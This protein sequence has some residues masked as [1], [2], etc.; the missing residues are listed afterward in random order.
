M[1]GNDGN[2]A[3][4]SS[5]CTTALSS[6]RMALLGML[7]WPAAAAWAQDLRVTAVAST[8]TVG[9]QDQFQLT[10]R[11]AGSDI[12]E[13]QVPVLPRLE[14]LDVVAGPSVSTQYQWV[15]GRASH[16]RS[17]IYI[18]VPTREGQFTIPP[19]EVVVAGEV[20]RTDPVEIR[21]TSAGAAPARG[22]PVP[23]DPSA[24]P[25]FDRTRPR[26]T[27]TTVFVTAELDRSSAYVG[28]QVTLSYFLY[29]QVTVSG[30]QLEESPALNGFWVED[31]EIDAKPAGTRRVVDGR[32]YL[33]Y[34][35]K[36][37]ALFPTAPGK[38]SVPPVTFAISARSEGG[39]FDWFSSTETLYRKSNE[40]GIEARALPAAG[41]PPNFGGA[42]GS[43]SLSGR[44][45]KNEVAAGD[46]VTLEVK[47]AG[48]GNLRM[49]PDLSLPPIPD[50]TVYS[51]KRQDNLRRSGG[52]PVGGEMVWEYIL[53]PSVPGPHSIRPIA[54]SFFDPERG[55]YETVTTE[56]L[57]VNVLRGGEN[58]GL[59]TGLPQAN[60]QNLTRQGTDIAFIKLSADDLSTAAPPLYRSLWFFVIAGIPVALNIGVFLLQR[61]RAREAQNAPLAR[62]RRARAAAHA[63]LKAAVKAGRQEP[64]RF[65]DQAALALSGYLEDRFDLPGI[66]LTEDTLERTLAERAVPIE[67]LREA[68]TCL[69]ECDF[70]RFVSPSSSP[71]SMQKLAGR[72]RKVVQALERS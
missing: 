14:G 44:V 12:G 6:V 33:V 8:D 5:L 15:N 43:F 7:L 29:T 46:A 55:A 39:V 30:L 31:L 62:S 51:S 71:E 63:R 50:F 20:H 2:P 23:P 41:R 4:A 56:P 60:R 11:I 47:L 65:Y 22:R 67:T 1:T 3:R 37:Q 53:V 9:V 32:E 35:V 61:E 26:S 64:R 40:I 10:I 18:L 68:T 28:Q 54:F 24:D 70:G 52:G 48:R 36:R 27:N 57:P 13:V 45:N 49:I 16:S 59:I 21:V 69:R 66:A 34:L 38:L 42:V 25:F 72:I 17:Y 19:V 58:A